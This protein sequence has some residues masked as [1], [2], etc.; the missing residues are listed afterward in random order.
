MLYKIY[1]ISRSRLYS[2]V[3]YLGRGIKPHKFPRCIQQAIPLHISA[4]HCCPAMSPVKLLNQDEAVKIDE[5]L[6]NEY[7][8]SVDQ[9]MELAGM[10]KKY[11]VSGQVKLF[12]HSI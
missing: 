2:K 9:L 3:Q 6:F 5:E 1:L 4:T 10:I 7:G 11:K 8:F 12:D